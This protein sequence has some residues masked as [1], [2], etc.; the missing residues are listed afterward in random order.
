L[1]FRPTASIWISSVMAWTHHRPIWRE[2]G[3]L[4]ANAA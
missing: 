3:D 2:T 4:P 1:L